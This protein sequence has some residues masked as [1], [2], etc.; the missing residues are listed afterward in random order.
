MLIV[1]ATC[2]GDSREGSLVVTMTV[3]L[4]FSRMFVMAFSKYWTA[5][6]PIFDGLLDTLP[7]I[8]CT[9]LL[10]RALKG[11]SRMTIGAVLYRHLA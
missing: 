9:I 5:L 2:A 10:S 11:E 3:L 4:F 7:R 6:L 1:T 8:L